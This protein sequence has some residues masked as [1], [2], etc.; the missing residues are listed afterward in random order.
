MVLSSQ[1]RAIQTGCIA[2][3]HLLDDKSAPFIAHED[4]RECSGVHTCDKRRPKSRQEKEFPMVDF[5]EIESEHDGLFRDDRRESKSDVGER[6]YSFL[7]WLSERPESHI[8]V[9]SHSGWLMTL[10][11]G[12]VECDEAL[13]PWFQTGELRSVKLEFTKK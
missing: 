8:G 10:F 5:S 2:F 11:N 4:V 1:C 3:E 7:R 9:A 6:I 12:V 13:K